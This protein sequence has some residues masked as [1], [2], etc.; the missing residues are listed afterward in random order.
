V[1]KSATYAV[2]E[3]PL[4]QAMLPLCAGGGAPGVAEDTFRTAEGRNVTLRIWVQA[5][6]EGRTAHAMRYAEE[7]HALG[8]GGMAGPV[9]HL[10][11]QCLGTLQCSGSC[12]LGRDDISCRANA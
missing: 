11:L 6:D 12:S 2:W 4:A 7:S 1:Q 10:A 5:G 8:R 3:G 9:S